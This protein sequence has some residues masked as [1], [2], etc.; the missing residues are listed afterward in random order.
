MRAAGLRRVVGSTGLLGVYGIRHDR[1][2][3]GAIGTGRQVGRGLVR[4]VVSRCRK[5]GMGF[6]RNAK[7]DSSG[8]GEGEC[9]WLEWITISIFEYQR[10]YYL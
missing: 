5:F 6:S 9:T 2:V 10:F 3:G 8:Q 7:L 1:W 4:S